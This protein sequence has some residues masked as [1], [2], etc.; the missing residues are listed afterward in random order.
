ME[1]LHEQYDNRAFYIFLDPSAKGLAEEIKRA[2]R[3]LEY[4]V[5]MRDAENDVALGISRVQKT[6]TF[7]I[8]SISPKQENAD[9]EFGTYEYD[10]KSIERGK[11]VPVKIDDHCC[12]AIRYAVMGAWDRIKHW[13][14]AEEQE[15]TQVEYI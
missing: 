6:M 10:K 3:A 5:F 7:D 13:L 15:V 8:L 4:S 12:D 14:P 9:R 1:G 11:E 2:T